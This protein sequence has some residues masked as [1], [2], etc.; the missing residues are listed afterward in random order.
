MNQIKEWWNGLQE[1]EQYI[2]GGG[3]IAL[4]IMLFW[5]AVWDPIS[6]G[7]VKLEK[8][9]ET[10]TTHLQEMKGNVAKIQQL[11]RMGGGIRSGNRPLVSLLGERI[12][13]SG[14]QQEKLTK[15]GSVNR[16]KLRFENQPFDS[17]IT[18]VGDLEQNHGI[19]VSSLSISPASDTGRVDIRVTMTRGD[20]SE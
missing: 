9:I 3:A 13:S 16:Y 17:F 2:V 10:N 20:G 7:V 8:N 19:Q 15:D 5:G 14:L 12:K 18:M 11:Q 1:R 6:D 4:V